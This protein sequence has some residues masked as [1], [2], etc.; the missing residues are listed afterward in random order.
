MWV[1]SCVAVALGAT[2]SPFPAA[3][4]AQCPGCDEYEFDLPE[5]PEEAPPA[6]APV[7][8][9]AP[10]YVPPTYVPPTT[11]APVAPPPDPEKAKRMVDSRSERGIVPIALQ[12]I[13]PAAAIS[14]GGAS[15]LPLALVIGV[16]TIIAV[17]IG[18]RRQVN[19]G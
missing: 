14:P 7:P 13:D 10:T 4:P 5:Q 17:A 3:A 12:P 16:A 9:T 15:L 19:A 8:P 11:V 18:F 1:V 6:A 2:F